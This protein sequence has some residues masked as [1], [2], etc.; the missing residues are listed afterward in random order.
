MKR[1][2]PF[3]A[4]LS[5]AL[6]LSLAL[7]G[8]GGTPAAST[9]SPEGTQQAEAGGKVLNIATG[10]EMNNLST[11]IM[12]P[13]N[14]CA[15]KLVYETLVIY[16]DGD[17]KPGLADS[18]DWSDDHTAL[19]FHLHQG[20]VFHDGT[21]FNAEAVKACLEYYVSNPN[22]GFL[23]GISTISSVDAVDESTVTVHYSAPYFA[24]L[25]DLSSADVVGMISPSSFEPGNFKSLKSF[26]GTGPYK[27][28]E[29]VSGEY[30][31]FTRNEDYW[32]EAPYWDEVVAKYI[33]DS[34]SRLKALQTGEVD[35][36][37]GSAMLTYDDYE[38]AITL[39]NVKGQIAQQDERTRNIVVNASGQM[40]ADVNVRRAVAMSI[41]KQAL[42]TGLTY[43]YE[44]AADRL[45]PEGTAHTDCQMNNTWSY[46]PEGA[47][48]LLDENGWVVDPSTGIREKDG[49]PLHMVFTYQEEVSINESIATAIKSQLA[50]V[51]IDVTLSG[52]EQML[53]WQAD[54]GGDYDLTIWNTNARATVPQ[55]YFSPWLDSSAGYAATLGL[56]EKAD[57]DAA[58][59]EYMTTADDARVDEIFRYLLNFSN[60]QVIDIPLTYTKEMIVYNSEKI[61]DYQFFGYSE[62]FDLFGLQ[63]AG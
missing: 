29:F 41:D 45:F 5:A 24:V 34:A 6:C 51:G 3:L 13:N 54:M 21:P 15:Q 30:T 4:A 39:P 42:S 46:D 18:W 48:A 44:N 37:F 47:K 8:C 36:I 55:T 40:C 20:V 9:T 50:Q 61:A 59:H 16:D 58:I 2:K 12:D 53:W 14:T 25:N 56:P 33:P 62:F 23:K 35:L 49:V 26:V 22:N 31:T 63:P 52:M 11:I 7:S 19:T 32:G 10:G 28:G 38:Q 27:Y 43:G 60:D 57:V 1:K 17:F